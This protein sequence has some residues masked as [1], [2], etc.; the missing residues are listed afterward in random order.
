M[1]RAGAIREAARDITVRGESPA[2]RAC[3]VVPAARKRNGRPR[4]DVPGAGRS[5][6]LE[7]GGATGPR[8]DQGAENIERNDFT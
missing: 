1:R 6:Y 5:E 2:H 4:C 7:V 3:P 8:V